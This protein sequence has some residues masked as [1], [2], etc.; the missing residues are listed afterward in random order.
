MYGRPVMKNQAAL[1]SLTE[2][3][4][5]QAVPAITAHYCNLNWWAF[6]FDGHLTKICPYLYVSEKDLL[7]LQELPLSDPGQSTNGQVRSGETTMADS[8]RKREE[9][10]SNPVFRES[11]RAGTMNGGNGLSG[12]AERIVRL[13]PKGRRRTPYPVSVR[14]TELR[15]Y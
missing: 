4:N 12:T 5:R 1:P 2:S 9:R 7:R 15:G 10:G 3:Q 11:D 6:R 8:E 13:A 14:K